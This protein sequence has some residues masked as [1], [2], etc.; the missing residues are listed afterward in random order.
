[1]I[2]RLSTAA[3]LWGSAALGFLATLVAIRS[4]SVTDVGRYG[5]VMGAVGF[6]QTLLDVTAEESAIKYGFRYIAR[7]E[8]GK[9]RRLLAG[10]LAFKLVGGLLAAAVLAGIAPAAHAIWSKV[11][12]LT[13]PLLVGA[14]LPVAQAAEGPAGIALYLRSRYDIRSLF[15]AVSMALRLAAVAIGVRF[16]LTATILAIVLAQVVATAAVSAVGWLAFRRFPSAPAERLGDDRRDILRFV[17]QSSGATSI[18]ALRTTLTVPLVG[19]VA[20]AVQTGYYRV[21]QAPQTGFAMLSAPARMV[22][23]TEQTRDWE[24]GS[25]DAV[26]RGVRRYSAAA[27]ALTVVVVPLLVW[28]M[29]DIVRILFKPKNLG[30][31][32]AA[33]FI[34]LAGGLQLLVGWS[35]SLPVALGRPNLRIW[36]HGLEALVLLPLT[37]LF[38]VWWGATGAGAAMAVSSAV[39]AA[40]WAVLFLRISRDVRA[41]P[42]EAQVEPPAEAVVR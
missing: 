19:A 20:S 6:V 1:M 42:G 23:L 33:R 27:L 24:R 5:V 11:P 30:A 15:L 22:L 25:R 18:I 39:F 38:A 8:W 7:E 14:A 34:V 32:D 3:G 36:T 37:A 40:S 16:G 10:T 41:A 28:L 4:F 35:K 9:L 29:P 31:V 17:L 12:D 21:A 2:R 13:V 26:L